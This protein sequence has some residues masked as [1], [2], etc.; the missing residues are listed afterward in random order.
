MV[1]STLSQL[2]NVFGIIPLNLPLN[3]NG[4]IILLLVLVSLLLILFLYI[5]CISTLGPHICKVWY[6]EIQICLASIEWDSPF[7]LVWFWLIISFYWG[8]FSDEASF[9]LYSPLHSYL[10]GREIVMYL[11]MLLVVIGFACYFMVHPYVTNKYFVVV[12]FCID[13]FP[14]HRKWLLGFL[15]YIGL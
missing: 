1:T 13:F 10:F 2:W 14:W 11:L 12:L 15:P 5:L 6:I 7:L 9:F 3:Y 4:M 8:A